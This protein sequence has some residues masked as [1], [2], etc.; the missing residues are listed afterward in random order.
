MIRVAKALHARHRRD[1]P[2][3]PEWDKTAAYWKRYWL[4]QAYAALIAQQEVF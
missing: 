1:K 4:E 3:Y 2:H